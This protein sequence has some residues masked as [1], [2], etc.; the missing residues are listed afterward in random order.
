MRTMQMPPPR[1]STLHSCAIG[2]EPGTQ[3]SDWETHLCGGSHAVTA[4]R[5]SMPG[6]MVT[7]T[8]TGLPPCSSNSAG[9]N[10]DEIPGPVAMAC[11]TSSGVPG[12]STSIWTER[13]P[14][15][16][17]FTLMLAPW[18]W[19]SEA[20]GALGGA[21]PPTLFGRCR[22]T[23]DHRPAAGDCER[24]LTASE[25]LVDQAHDLRTSECG[26]ALHVNPARLA[27]PLQ[28]FRRIPHFLA[29]SEVQLDAVR[30]RADS[31]NA[32]V[33]APAR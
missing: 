25:G 12:T 6:P 26:R 9:T 17:F 15:G 19:I 31:K 10:Q 14:D 11:Q 3:P 7:F 8:A 1:A 20:D 29:T 18:D 13:R 21:T 16:S 27:G 2:G 32:L 28:Q 24:H 22:R 23:H 33:P 4:E 30:V 5:D